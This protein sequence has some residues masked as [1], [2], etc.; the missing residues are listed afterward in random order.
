[1]RG[2]TIDIITT[3]TREA[4]LAHMDL[5]TAVIIPT[6]YKEGTTVVTLDWTSTTAFEV[7]SDTL[8]MVRAIIST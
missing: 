8:I 6:I 5:L 2:I 4:L 1:L 7:H 3:S